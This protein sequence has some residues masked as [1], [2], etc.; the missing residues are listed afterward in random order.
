MNRSDSIVSFSID[1][2]KQFVEAQTIA[3][4]GPM[5]SGEARPSE[6]PALKIFSKVAESLRS[7]FKMRKAIVKKSS[8]DDS[9]STFLSA[10][11]CSKTYVCQ[12]ATYRNVFEKDSEAQ[13][14]LALIFASF[15]MQT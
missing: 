10:E 15:A 9:S 13:Q 6:P 12:N 4:R 3:P 2:E 5:Q 1:V 8:L 14:A 11:K 7:C